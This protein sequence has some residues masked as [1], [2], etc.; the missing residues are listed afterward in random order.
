M[1]WTNSA[2]GGAVSQTLVGDAG[3]LRRDARSYYGAA[4]DEAYGLVNSEELRRCLR[5]TPGPVV[6]AVS[7]EIYEGIVRHDDDGIDQAAYERLAIR[8]T[9]RRLDAWAHYPEP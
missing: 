9:Q 8:L 1:G 7:P 2:G 5:Q 3:D 4:L 6:L